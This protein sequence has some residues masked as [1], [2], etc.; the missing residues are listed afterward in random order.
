[1]R[2]ETVKTLTLNYHESKLISIQTKPNGQRNDIFSNAIKPMMDKIPEEC[3]RTSREEV[4]RGVF[5]HNSSRDTYIVKWK[6]GCTL[7]KGDNVFIW[8][9]EVEKVWA[10]T[11][12][13]EDW[14]KWSLYE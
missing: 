12:R 14:P 10:L 7:V 1:V 13:S 6:Y 3:W 4:V 9:P 5:I 8:W 2:S 11:D